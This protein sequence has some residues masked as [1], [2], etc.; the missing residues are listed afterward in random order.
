MK[1]IEI[2]KSRLQFLVGDITKQDTQAVVNAANKRLAKGGGVAGAIHSAAGP[3]LWEECS[4]LGGCDT[5]EAK[6]TRAY[7][8]PNEYVIHT[9]GPV[10]R[11]SKDDPLLL[12]S[13]YINSLKLADTK[14]IASIAFPALSTG[15]FGYPIDA[16]AQV[17]IKAIKSY[18][19]QDTQIEIVRMVLYN[20]ASY[21]AHL[22]AL[23]ALDAGVD[24]S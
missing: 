2:G 24:L 1:E 10:Y 23:K 6:I 18:L 3:K 7:D 11:G 19:Y 22:R 9:V 21:E 16:A 8:L 13:C 17:C 14:G 20:K 12:R 4:T 15:I 5:G